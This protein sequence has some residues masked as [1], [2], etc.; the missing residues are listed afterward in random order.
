MWTRGVTVNRIAVIKLEELWKQQFKANFPETV[1]EDVKAMSKENPQFMDFVSHSAKLIIGHNYIGL[2]FRNA[3]VVLPMNRIIVEQ[4]ALIL[5]K[6][7][8]LNP[9]LHA[10]HTA[11]MEDVIQKVYAEKVPVAELE[12]CDGRLWCIPHHGVHH[13]KKNKIRVVFDCV[14]SF[15][16]TLL[17]SMLL[18]GPNLTS[19]LVSVLVRF[20]LSSVAMMADV[21][22]M[23]YQVRVHPG[24]C[25]VLRFLW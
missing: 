3:E 14:A 25:D 24:D 12:R 2:P 8:K 20:G 1:H 10:D 21:E 22:C 16:G 4:R 17:N 19:S 7:F 5:Q 18:P 13:P 9:S 23:F 11:F 6:R 15:Q